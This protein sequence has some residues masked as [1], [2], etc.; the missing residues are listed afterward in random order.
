MHIMFKP[1]FGSLQIGRFIDSFAACLLTLSLYYLTRSSLQFDLFACTRDS[2]LPLSLAKM[3]LGFFHVLRPHKKESMAIM[4]YPKFTE[5]QMSCGLRLQLCAKSLNFVYFRYGRPCL[6]TFKPPA[7]V[8]ISHFAKNLLPL[9][10]RSSFLRSSGF[11][12]YVFIV[13]A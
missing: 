11:A 4:I 2:A 3:Q 7:V 1:S 13:S 6:C 9:L 5:L 12:F 8:Q 10:S